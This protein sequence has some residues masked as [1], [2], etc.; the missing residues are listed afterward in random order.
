[1]SATEAAVKLSDQLYAIRTGGFLQKNMQ[2]SLFFNPSERGSQDDVFY[3]FLEK[4]LKP[5]SP[6]QPFLP[7]TEIASSPIMYTYDSTKNSWSEHNKSSIGSADVSLNMCKC[8]TSGSPF[9][10]FMNLLQI[11]YNVLDEPMYEKFRN[12]KI[13]TLTI[14]QYTLDASGQSQNQTL[15]KDTIRTILK[16]LF[17]PNI[18]DEEIGLTYETNV[19]L[20]RRVIRMYML[21]AHMQLAVLIRTTRLTN[22]TYDTTVNVI[23]TDNDVTMKNL[24]GT[25]ESSV[26]MVRNPDL[27]LGAN[28]N[29]GQAFSN[30][31]R[32]RMIYKY[33]VLDLRDVYKTYGNINGQI[34]IVYSV[35]NGQNIFYSSKNQTYYRLESTGGTIVIP[36]IHANG[37]DDDRTLYMTGL[38]DEG[39][40]QITS[41]SWSGNTSRFNFMNSAYDEII[42]ANNLMYQD[43]TTNHQE[44]IIDVSNVVKNQEK[45]VRKYSL[46]L[47]SMDEKI[48]LMKND[49]TKQL[50]SLEQRMR[51]QT[52][53]GR[54]QYV[55]YIVLGLIVIGATGAWAVTDVPMQKLIA[56]YVLGFAVIMGLVMYGLSM[57]FASKETFTNLV[58]DLAGQEAASET[59]N[60]NAIAATA[61][62]LGLNAAGTYLANA[63][64]IGMSLT[65]YKI[66]KDLHGIL[67]KEAYKYWNIK[68]NMKQKLLLLK[69]KR[70]LIGQKNR[71]LNARVTLCIWIGLVVGCATYLIQTLPMFRK[72]ILGIACFG[73]IIGFLAYILYIASRVHT[74]AKEV[75]WPIPEYGIKN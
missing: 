6:S 66:F 11:L 58:R 7:T 65:S 68:G 60:D 47:D 21:M 19:V 30:A 25:S 15:T 67:S 24:L 44:S 42:H 61:L 43:D 62:D 35:G 39:D 16:V 50:T 2:T 71:I 13:A 40:I 51:S 1:M 36:N 72:V 8:V 55:S 18:K 52:S 26:A 3:E 46:N 29:F 31:S 5:F 63:I 10:Q 22:V 73:L 27:P 49:L 41:V 57:Y 23:L 56:V 75:Y 45:F 59:L 12:P 9:L 20:L 53:L 69:A 38:V 37:S 64:Q 48:R 32:G 4:C 28:A 17:Q 34:T 54:M 74:S 14:P 70:E 33:K